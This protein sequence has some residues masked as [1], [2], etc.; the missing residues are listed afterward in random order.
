MCGYSSFDKLNN[1][2]F[3]DKYVGRSLKADG[4][5]EMFCTFF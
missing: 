5:N 4:L 3:V 1:R 2:I